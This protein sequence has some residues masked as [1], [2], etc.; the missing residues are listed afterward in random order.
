ML[1]AAFEIKV[2]GPGQVRLVAEHRG[3]ARPASN[4]TSMMSISLRN[5]VPPHL[6]HFVPDGRISDGLRLYQASEPSLREQLND[7]CD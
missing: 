7:G 5:F 2:G 1:V 3:V 4:H 6:A